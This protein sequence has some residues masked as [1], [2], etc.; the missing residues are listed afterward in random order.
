[1]TTIA[2]VPHTIQ[3]PM[4]SESQPVDISLGRDPGSMDFW[5]AI[6]L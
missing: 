6:E 5:E 2:T 1:M 3:F 4:Q